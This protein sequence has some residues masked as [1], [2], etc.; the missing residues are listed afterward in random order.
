MKILKWNIDKDNGTFGCKINKAIP[1]RVISYETLYGEKVSVK[2]SEIRKR[3]RNKVKFGC[4][5][6]KVD[7]S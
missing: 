4:V 1:N 6:E 5:V 7:L 3:P 2:S